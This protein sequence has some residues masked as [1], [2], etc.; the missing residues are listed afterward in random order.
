M[1][2]VPAVWSEAVGA[3]C[4][5]RMNMRNLWC[6]VAFLALAGCASKETTQAQPDMKLCVDYMTLPSFNIHQ[7]ARADE[8]ARRKLDCEQYAGLIAAKW[9]ADAAASPPPRVDVDCTGR[10]DGNGNVRMNCQ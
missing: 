3:R 2:V 6:A 4:N 8:I 7:G 1:E 5:W 9:G 10:A